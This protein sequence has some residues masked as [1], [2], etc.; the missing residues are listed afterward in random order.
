M[1][2]GL[3]AADCVVS[4]SDKYSGLKQ[5]S[6]DYRIPLKLAA[7]YGQFD[8]FFFLGFAPLC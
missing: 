7:R 2:A 3:V 1:P 6:R 5:E 4:T 8:L